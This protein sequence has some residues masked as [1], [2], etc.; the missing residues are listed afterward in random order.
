M[1]G[2]LIDDLRTRIRAGDDITSCDIHLI[3]K[4]ERDCI[5]CASFREVSVGGDDSGYGRLSS[6]GRDS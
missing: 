6:G 5:P 1:C 3:T 2:E 4:G